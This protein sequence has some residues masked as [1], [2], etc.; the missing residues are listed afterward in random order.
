VLHLRQAHWI[1][2]ERQARVDALERE[3]AQAQLQAL[4]L[5][6]QPHFLFNAL[7]AISALI[8]ENPRAA[9]RMVHSLGEFLRRVLRQNQAQ[10]VPLKEEIDFAILYMEIMKVRFEERLEFKLS[11]D[12]GLEGI[13]VPQLIL[14]PLVENAVLHGTDGQ[15]GRAEVSIDVLRTGPNV[16]LHV[17]NRRHSESVA[18]AGMGLGL[19]N[20]AQRLEKLY[21]SNA[22]L[23]MESQEGFTDVRVSVPL[24]VETGA[25]AL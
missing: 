13:L 25:T 17:R 15:T 6:I 1:A 12:A 5:Q 10:E 21:G 7:N 4:Q 16:E 19:K 3:L 20:V 8:E 22:S 18:S 24:R 2:V 11:C 14:Q 23:R 9:D